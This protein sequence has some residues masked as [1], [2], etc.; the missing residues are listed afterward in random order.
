MKNTTSIEGVVDSVNID[1]RSNNYC[2]LNLA[3]VIGDGSTKEIKFPIL[4]RGTNPRL[5]GI[6]ENGTFLREAISSSLLNQRVAYKLESDV[7]AGSSGFSY[8]S[9]ERHQLDI[10]SGP[11]EG[12]SCLADEY[13]PL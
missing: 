11:L 3:V 9:H 6:E 7:D 4:K 8:S 2:Y 10:L 1:N 13:D 5:N 12:R